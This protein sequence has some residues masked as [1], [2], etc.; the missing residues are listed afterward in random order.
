MGEEGT[1]WVRGYHWI[2]PWNQI[3]AT[4]GDSGHIWVPMDDEN[5][6]V[7]NWNVVFED[8]PRDTPRP[9]SAPLADTPDLPAWFRNARRP[10]GSGNEF[11]VDVDPETS[12]SV[13][14]PDHRYLN[15]RH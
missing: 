1:N 3:R 15:D 4:G 10:I 14:N 6:M 9:V 7:Y 5:T 12:R 13:P 2:M 11:I 8:T